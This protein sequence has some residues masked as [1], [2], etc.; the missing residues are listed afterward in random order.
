MISQ[1]HKLVAYQEAM[2]V[3]HDLF[4]EVLGLLHG[5]GINLLMREFLHVGTTFN[6]EKKSCLSATMADNRIVEKNQ[7]F[8]EETYW[9]VTCHQVSPSKL[10]C[11]CST[12]LVFALNCLAAAAYP[13]LLI[14]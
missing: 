13:V 4:K 5:Q 11:Q 10:P 14:L 12:P 3:V 2:P 1:D 8:F 6:D 7:V 9:G